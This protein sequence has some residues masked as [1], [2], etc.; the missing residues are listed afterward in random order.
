M[1]AICLMIPCAFALVACGGNG[2]GAGGTGGSSNGGGDSGGGQAITTTHTVNFYKDDTLVGTRTY[3]DQN[4]FMWMDIPYVQGDFEQRGWFLDMGT[5]QQE[6]VPY[7]E[8]N[9]IYQQCMSM[10]ASY[11]VHLYYKS[12]FNV[13][14]GDLVSLSFSLMYNLQDGALVVPEKVTDSDGT[15]T[16]T[17]FSMSETESYNNY[18]EVKSI[19]LP[20]TVTEVTEGALGSFPQL[21]SINY[22]NSRYTVSNTLIDTQTKTLIWASS[23]VTEIPS[24]VEVIGKSCFKGFDG[25]SITIPSGITRIGDSAFRDSDL[26]SITIPATVTYV[27]EHAFDYASS[28]KT[29][30]FEQSSDPNRGLVIGEGCFYQTYLDSVT[31]PFVGRTID[32]S[33]QAN[34]LFETYRT[35]SNFVVTEA[36]TLADRCFSAITCT[37]L[38]LPKSLERIGSGIFDSSYLPYNLTVPF[39]GESRTSLQ[40]ANL[41]Y[42]VSTQGYANFYNVVV[43]DGGMVAPNFSNSSVYTYNIQFESFMSV[44]GENAFKSNYNCKFD[45]LLELGIE[46]I[47]AGAFEN[48]DISNIKLGAGTKTIGEGAFKNNRTMGVIT[49]P[50]GLQTIGDNAFENTDATTIVIPSS[51]VSIGAGAFK[52]TD[53]Y[54]DCAI[55]SITFS[56]NNLLSVG[57]N[58][59]ENIPLIT[60]L[61]LPT[62]VQTIGNG[63]LRNSM[64]VQKL[65]IPYVSSVYTVFGSSM[66]EALT[67]VTF[68]NAT[69]V[70]DLAFV[71]N[72]VANITK[73]TLN[74]EVTSIGTNAFPSSVTTLNMPTSLKEIKDRAFI[75]CTLLEN[76]VLPDAL[77]SIGE[78]A[79]KDLANIFDVVKIGKNVTHIGNGAFAGVEFTGVELHAENTTFTSNGQFL[80]DE[81]NK[82]VL[83]G[84]SD[85]NVTN[86]VDFDHNCF[87]G[88]ELTNVTFSN[89]LNSIGDYA[90]ANTG[91]TALD[92]PI[93]TQTIGEGAF[94]NCPVVNIKM[95]FVGLSRTEPTSTY[96][97]F[98]AALQDTLTTANIYDCEILGSMSRLSKL[99]NVTLC[100]GIAIF[101]NGAF[102]GCTSLT[103]ITLPKELTALSESAFAG[104]TKLTTINFNDK[105]TTIADGAL[106]SCGFTYFEI[107]NTV[108]HLGKEAFRNCTSLFDIYIPNS[109]DYIGG[110]S[111][112]PLFLGCTALKYV[113]CA[114]ES[115]D[116]KDGFANGWCDKNTLGTSYG[117]IEHTYF[118]CVMSEDKNW[119]YNEDYTV[120][121]RYRG[122][123]ENITL[124]S[125]IQTLEKHAFYEN[126]SIKTIDLSKTSLTSIVESCFAY[127]TNLTTVVLPESVTELGNTAFFECVNL[128]D[129]NL[130]KVKVF[131]FRVFS[132]CE[133]LTNINISSAEEIHNSAFQFVPIKTTLLV[134]PNTLKYFANNAF[135]P[136][137]KTNGTVEK[138]YVPAS[139][140]TLLTYDN[141]EINYQIYFERTTAFDNLTTVPDYYHFDCIY[142][143]NFLL[144]G[145]E[146]I[147]YAT[148]V[149]GECVLPESVTTI[150]SNMFAGTTKVT[151]LIMTDNVTTINRLGKAA[152][153][154]HVRL[155]A[156]IKEYKDMVFDYNSTT[157]ESVIF[158][159]GVKYIREELRLPSCI[160][161]IFIPS[162]CY[163][164]T[165]C[166]ASGATTTLLYAGSKSELNIK[167]ANLTQRTLDIYYYMTPDC[168]SKMDTL[169]VELEAM[170]TQYSGTYEFV[171]AGGNVAINNYL[172]DATTNLVI[173]DGIK[174]INDGFVDKGIETIDF[175]DVEY[176]LGGLGSNNF[177]SLD[178][179]NIK[180]IGASAFANCT[181]LQSVDLSN[182]MEVHNLAFTNCTSLASVT[183]GQTLR[184]LMFGAFSN[185]TSLTTL[186]VPSSIEYI[187][188]G[189]QSSTGSSICN[190]CVETLVIYTDAVESNIDNVNWDLSW[191]CKDSSS[192]YETQYGVKYED[193]LAIINAA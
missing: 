64:A 155:S 180:V 151:S 5:W 34:Y 169:K 96:D 135:V 149:E 60:S 48:C 150:A 109:V 87:N 39:L 127:C 116:A 134:L 122:T 75:G 188:S 168:V 67:E 13:V 104:C 143:N 133:K 78:Y 172:G 69:K 19:T 28:L 161:T 105:L 145:D 175:N 118:N 187:Y 76:I 36:K 71:Y 49:L 16:I 126:I 91:L 131:S 166:I 41:N 119:V 192:D 38:T 1:L 130:S 97:M 62:S 57:A 61:E 171:I 165:Y 158:P 8:Y 178:L 140:E 82:R 29:V 25:T 152:G 144:S 90:F 153:L 3:S 52:N 94:L 73:I 112:A 138:I 108:T 53:Q 120:I 54:H 65:T 35:I 47:Q 110:H 70:D 20:S 44:V 148:T 170:N 23:D 123:E 129:I 46:E 174:S 189:T 167:S 88:V 164:E 27:G 63:I 190:G 173:P 22:S 26:T 18:S 106:A 58:A 84:T 4:Q 99:T 136:N 121:K 125:R 79:F 9:S 128:T 86:Y 83:I 191:N 157:I 68:T 33:R 139:V 115:Y 45:A 74:N 12:Y 100:D 101:A 163:F 14:D 72:G 95:P 159:A 89:Q 182:T 10:P 56:G 113:Y 43:T 102:S 40:N 11:D 92:L 147:V 6:F 185:C 181:L 111:Y 162:N 31:I 137:F 183:L 98:G 80:T 177:T 103:E 93:T 21:K 184:M 7:D 59:F 15:Q 142:K 114:F 186:Y 146:T 141:D 117:L 85:L 132:G 179:T 160:K 24:G 193:Y 32:D 66:P 51:V 37:N 81:A 77:E 154:K 50:E 17:K 176:V 124:D 42:F 156:G 55:A 107:P 2:D 30:V